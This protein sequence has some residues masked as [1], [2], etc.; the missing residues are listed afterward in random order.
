[1]D[2]F[3]G[4]VATSKNFW[5]RQEAIFWAFHGECQYGRSFSA[6]PQFRFKS[7]L[8]HLRQLCPIGCDCLK[9]PR[10]AWG[11][12][13]YT[14]LFHEVALDNRHAGHSTYRSLFLDLGFS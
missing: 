8:Q 3:Y 12:E 4:T 7:S 10:E 6:A 11:E 1:M 13:R 14:E 2:W 9:Q 5:K